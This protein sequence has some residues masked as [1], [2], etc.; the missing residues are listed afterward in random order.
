MSIR[1]VNILGKFV[2]CWQLGN[3]VS[4]IEVTSYSKSETRDIT[5]CTENKNTVM[6]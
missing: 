3:I 5:V 6:T 2:V 4:H 1:I